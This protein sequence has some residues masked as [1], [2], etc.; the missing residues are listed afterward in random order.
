M[1]EP[2]SSFARQSQS[3]DMSFG[4][5]AARPGP[6]PLSDDAARN[7]ALNPSKSFV[8]ESPAGAGKTEL[9]LRRYL[10]LLTQVDD[11]QQVLAITFTRKAAGEIRN[12]VL[13]ALRQAQMTIGGERPQN[14]TVKLAG[15]I[16]G[17]NWNLLDYPAALRILTIDS[18]NAS[19]AQGLPWQ[20]RL[21][22]VMRPIEDAQQQE[23][24]ELAARRLLRRITETTP[25]ADAVRMLLPHFDNHVDEVEKRLACMLAQRDQWLRRIGVQ[26]LRD[27]PGLREFRRRLEAAHHAN[28]ERQLEMLIKTLPAAL[29]DEVLAALCMANPGFSGLDLATFCTSEHLPLWQGLTRLLLTKDHEWRK[30]WDKNNGIEPDEKDKK[31]RLRALIQRLSEEARLALAHVNSLPPAVFPAARWEDMQNLLTLLPFAIAELKLIWAERGAVDFIEMAQAAC[32]ALGEPESPTDLGLAL[33]ARIQHILI[34]EFQ[35]TSAAQFELLRRLTCGWQAGDGRTLFL[36]GDPKQSIYGWRQAQVGLFLRVE[37]LLPELQLQRLALR[38]NFR[39]DKS[40]ITWV[41]CVFPVPF[42]QPAGPLADAVRFTPAEP[43]PDANA[44]MEVISLPILYTHLTRMHVAPL[45]AREREAMAVAEQVRRL[46]QEFMRDP[47][48]RNEAPASPAS[49]ARI[50]ILLRARSHARQIAAALRQQK[51]AFQAVSLAPLGSSQLIQDLRAL[52]RALAY[53]GDRTAWLAVLRAPWCGLTLADLHALAADDHAAPMLDLLKR[54]RLTG[55]AGARISRVLPE[56]QQGMR[57]RRA[58]GLRRAVEA[59]WLRLGGPA[60]CTELESEQML[61]PLQAFWQLL[62]ECEYGGELR[63]LAGWEEQLQVLYAP[64]APSGDDPVQVQMMTLH[65]AKGLEFEAVILPC[66]DRGTGNHNETAPPLLW[67]DARA[68]DDASFLLGMTAVRGGED[69][70]HEYLKLLHRQRRLEE[71]K[72]LLYVAATR[73]RHHLV[74]SGCVG[75]SAGE[76][77]EPREDSL[78]S[79]LWPAIRSGWKAVASPVPITDS[80]ATESLAA[81]PPAQPQLRRLRLGWQPPDWRA[82]AA[83]SVIPVSP[84]SPDPLPVSFDW[85]GETLRL[86]GI[87]VHAWLER[88]HR[89]CRAH[90][91]SGLAAW[92][93]ERLH[94]LHPRL[95][96]DLAAAGVPAAE[97]KTA[98]RDAQRALEATLGDE[99]GRWLLAPHEEDHSEWELTGILD[100]RLHQI[101]IDR[102]FMDRGERWIADYKTS[103]HTGGNLELF[104]E[105]ECTR[106]RDQ[107][108]LYARLLQAI[109]PARG[110]PLRLGL[111]F[112]LLG[113]WREIALEGK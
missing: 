13:E 15:E 98:A 109:E 100:G 21:G 107:L 50:A 18:F 45:A 20:A 84:A 95:L 101:R 52:T 108:R 28:I 16:A 65:A 8:V 41:N 22:G 1:P 96:A 46:R 90:P 59:V 105:Q 25:V 23:C 48:A 112:P 4:A 19:L 10:T 9:L 51:I 64:V 99:R 30:R 37:E 69:K 103:R 81:Q 11:P 5:A 66:L 35:D 86:I 7:A 73:A 110:L 104:L 113:S 70:H 55:E 78:L 74:L 31:L 42:S 106:Y 79:K 32:Q 47:R 61:E 33:D 92:G 82:A 63:D 56:L 93:K 57:E 2:E 80:T 38:V 102:T 3:L 76:L 44:G 88:M 94:A 24:Y 72:R 54:K 17:K 75:I 34:D 83:S 87:V 6:A 53:P 97:L 77:R 40:L 85:V 67:L 39:S 71:D 27:E 89:H 60:V 26:S 62:E 58:F 14:L 91:E 12:R 49:P 68:G 43:K 36:V 29:S 111:Y